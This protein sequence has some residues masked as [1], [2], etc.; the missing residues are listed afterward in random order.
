MERPCIPDHELWTQE[1]I[2][3]ISGLQLNYIQANVL[4]YQGKNV[5]T[6]SSWYIKI[7]Q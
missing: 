6:H 2:L 7:A 4:K 5:S 1:T 3:E